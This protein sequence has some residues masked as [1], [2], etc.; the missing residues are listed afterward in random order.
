MQLNNDNIIHDDNP[1]I[2]TR[3]HNV[4]L[5]LSDEDR[6]LLTAMY[7]Y[8]RDSRSDELCEKRNLTPAVG[9]AA[10]QVGIPKKMIAVITGE[11]EDGTYREWALVNPKITSKS[12]KLAYLKSGEGCLSVPEGHQ[13]YVCRPDKITVKAWDL[14]TGQDVEIKTE[15]FEAIVLQH[16]IDHLSGGLYY[17]HINPKFPDSAP[18][19][20]IVIE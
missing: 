1:L 13:G 8:V 19:D 4:P 7:E 6:D 5:P 14:L 10:I 9:I 16:E 15:G 3:S 12:R 11:E 17:D 2:R 18:A 20:A